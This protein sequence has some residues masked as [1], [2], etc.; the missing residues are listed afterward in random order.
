MRYKVFF[1]WIIV[2]TVFLNMSFVM[3]IKSFPQIVYGYAH[4]CR[5]NIQYPSLTEEESKTRGC[6]ISRYMDETGQ[7]GFLEYQQ[8]YRKEEKKNV[9]TDHCLYFILDCRGRSSLLKESIIEPNIMYHQR[10]RIFFEMSDRI[11]PV[12][13]PDSIV[14]SMSEKEKIVFKR[15]SD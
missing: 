9:N 2:G 15:V 4:H 3:A 12:Q 11:Q 13:V 5:F 8:N 6:F 14:L 7:I 10:K 1:I